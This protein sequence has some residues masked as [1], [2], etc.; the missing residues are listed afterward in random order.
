[1]AARTPWYYSHIPAAAG[2]FLPEPSQATH[3]MATEQ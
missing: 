1:M 3:A 2:I